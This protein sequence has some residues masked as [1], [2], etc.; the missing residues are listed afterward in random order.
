MSKY[1][2]NNRRYFINANFCSQVRS[3]LTVGDFVIINTYLL[4]LYQPLNFLGSVYREIRQAIIDMENMFNL[5]KIKTSKKN[6]C[7]NLNLKNNLILH[8]K[9]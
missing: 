9:M 1:N 5:L 2:N 4:Q 3:E 6:L 7:E 8:L